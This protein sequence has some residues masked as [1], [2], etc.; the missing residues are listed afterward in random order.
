M[1]EFTIDVGGEPTTVRRGGDGPPLLFLH[2]EGATSGWRAA[3]DE[4]A[5]THTVFAPVLPGFGGT[6]LPDWLDGVDD[7]A[8]HLVDTIV[9]LG[10][11]RPLVVGESIG[12]WAALSLAIHR[13]DL[14]TGVVAIGALG[15][16]NPDMADLFIQPGPDVVRM[17]SNTLP[18]DVVDPLTGDAD[19]ATALWCDQAAQARLMWKRPYDRTLERRAHHLTCPVLV[20]WGAEDRLL[21]LAHGQRLAELVGARFVTMERAGHLATVDAPAAVAHAVTTFESER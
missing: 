3:H 18:A 20:V 17:L 8:F 5:R 4:L 11:Q 9:A 7:L 15:L 13:P 19:A 10:L 16:R 1:R 14:L 21:P 12:A 6:D 2:G